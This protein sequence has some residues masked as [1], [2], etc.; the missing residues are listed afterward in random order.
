MRPTRDYR[1][2]ITGEQ[3]RL[4]PISPLIGTPNAVSESYSSTAYPTTNTVWIINPRT[5]NPIVDIIL[6]PGCRPGISDV[7]QF[8]ASGKQIKDPKNNLCC[9][10]CEHTLRRFTTQEKRRQTINQSKNFY[11]DLCNRPFSSE[12]DLAIH[13]LGKS[14]R[15][16]ARHCSALS[17]WAEQL[18]VDF[19]R[20]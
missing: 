10:P 4:R 13:K 19:R 11:C 20:L 6:F 17:K 5:G 14:H 7:W 8:R 3:R 1:C 2:A 9:T 12:H 16:N 18:Y 15:S